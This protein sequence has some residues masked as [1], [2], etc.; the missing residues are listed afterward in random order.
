MYELAEKG[1]LDR[2]I[3]EKIEAEFADGSISTETETTALFQCPVCG[4]VYEGDVVPDG[5]VCPVCNQPGF[6][7][8]LISISLCV[9]M[10]EN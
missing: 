5:Y 4:Y 2:A 9:L 6:H 1:D 10:L 8:N 3:V 7:F